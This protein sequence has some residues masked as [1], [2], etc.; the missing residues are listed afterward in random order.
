MAVTTQEV[1][2]RR[3]EYLETFE[4][5]LLDAILG[6]YDPEAGTFTGG[7]S[8]A[9]PNLANIPGLFQI[10]QYTM[11][12]QPEGG[13]EQM[14][15]GALQSDANGNGVPDFLERYQ[16]YFEQ[17]GQFMT[18]GQEALYRGLGSLGDAASFFGPAAGYISGATGTYDPS[19]SVSQ[20]MNPYTEAV[21]D[22]SM[23]DIEREGDVARQKAAARAVGAGAFG[24]SREGLERAEVER[25]ILDTK[26]KQAANLRSAGY[27]QAL[28][29]SQ[30][31]YQDAM[32]RNL[33]AGRLTGGLGQ[34][35]GQLGSQ[36]GT[37]GQQYGQLGAQTADIGRV[38][39][40]LAP[41][42]LATMYEFGGAQRAYDQSVLDTARREA[43]RPTEQAL[44]PY[45]YAYEVLS[46][47]PS[48]NLYG[49]YTTG[50]QP[51]ANP[52][53]SGLGAYSALQGVYGGQQ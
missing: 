11:A 10:P 27:G 4:K 23:R 3:P 44:L 35:L 51:Q 7:I 30:K 46:G 9:T 43:M 38:F 24:G 22:A 45:N 31:A 33:E 26:A 42:D 50:Y 19:Q 53:I 40:A 28:E 14:A 32:T 16:P 8:G 21:I 1:V 36:Y 20:F 25:A 34:S 15:I 37:M 47:T 49:T 29:S 52:Y 48:A 6:Q 39:S 13:L 41:A 2:Q 18:G 12:T 17:A 5:G